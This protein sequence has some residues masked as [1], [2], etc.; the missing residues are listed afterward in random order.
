[1]YFVNLE[2]FGGFTEKEHASL[3]SPRQGRGVGDSYQGG[4]LA[5]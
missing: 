1:M 3:T 2:F 5:S 4:V